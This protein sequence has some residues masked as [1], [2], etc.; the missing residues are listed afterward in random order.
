MVMNAMVV[1]DICHTNFALEMKLMKRVL[2]RMHLIPCNGLE[3]SSYN[4]VKNKVQKY[5]GANIS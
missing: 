4:K 3:K 1:S 5:S 2:M